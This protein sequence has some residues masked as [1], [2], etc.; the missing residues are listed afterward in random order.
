MSAPGLQPAN[1]R[2]YFLHFDPRKIAAVGMLVLYFGNLQAS[3]VEQSKASVYSHATGLSCNFGRDGQAVRLFLSNSRNCEGSRYPYLEIDIQQ[4]PI[5]SKHRITIG[6][7]NSAFRCLGGREACEQARSVVVV[8][9]RYEEKNDN[10]RLETRGHFEVKFR[11][12]ETESADF[13][14][15]CYA[16]CA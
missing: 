16:P 9:D 10:G 4:L 2:Q 12:E 15:D 14:V 8:F 3:S 1:P 5:R 11:G 6:E 13:T 7:D